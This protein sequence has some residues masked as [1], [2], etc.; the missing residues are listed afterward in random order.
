MSAAKGL[1]ISTVA[2]SVHNADTFRVVRQMGVDRVQGYWVGRPR[3]ATNLV[4]GLVLKK[5]A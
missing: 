4:A 2:E 5:A 1:G 3:K